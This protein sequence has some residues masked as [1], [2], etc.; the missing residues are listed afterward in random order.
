[1]DAWRARQPSDPRRGRS[2]AAAASVFS[3]FCLEFFLQSAV[4]VASEQ[5]K[6]LEQLCR[7]ITRPALANE[8]LS[9]NSKGQVVLQLKSA[10]RDGTT[11]IVMQAQ[12][13]MQRLA[14]LVPRR[15]GIVLRTPKVRTWPKARIRRRDPK[16]PL[17]CTL[18]NQTP[19]NNHG[20]CNGSHPKP[21]SVN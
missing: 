16:L 2:K 17:R 14:A 4:R 9:R 20:V 15:T 3:A 19:I 13:F 1:M 6:A 12:E 18:N 5:R 21:R 8:R 11:H 7:Y 10:Y